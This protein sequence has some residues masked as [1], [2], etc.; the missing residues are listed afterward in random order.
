MPNDL[1]NAIFWQD[2]EPDHQYG[3]RRM[4]ARSRFGDELEA[5]ALAERRIVS[6]KKVSNSSACNPCYF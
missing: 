1:F 2:E 5:E 6:A 3:S 4:P